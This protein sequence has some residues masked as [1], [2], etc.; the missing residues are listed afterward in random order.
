MA[1]RNT[2]SHSPWVR[3]LSLACTAA[4]AACA[5]PGT[6][7]GAPERLTPPAVLKWVPDSAATNVDTRYAIVQFDA[8]VSER[9]SAASARELKDLVLISP[10]HGDIDVDWRRSSLRI[11]PKNGWKKNTTYTITIAPG[12]SDLQNNVRD[13]AIITVF[14]TGGSL[15]NGSIRGT[16]FNWETGE[17]AAGAIVE[18]VPTSDTTSIYITKTDSIGNFKLRTPTGNQFVVRSSINTLGDKVFDRRMA[19]DTTVI[20]LSDTASVELRAFQRDSIGPSLGTIRYEDSTRLSV[21]FTGY[22]D[23]ETKIDVSQF[24]LFDP[25]SNA[26]VIDSIGSIP[27]S[28]DMDSTVAT[29]ILVSKDTSGKTDTLI[30]T[31]TSSIS[32]TLIR[33]D[34]LGKA[35][36][37][38]RSDT[39]AKRDTISRDTV[40]ADSIAAKQTPVKR[41]I[42]ALKR[43]IILYLSRPLAD[44]KEY[45]LAATGIKN[46]NGAVG[47]SKR[48]FKTPA[49][50]RDK[51][52]TQEKK[53]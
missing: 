39:L 53:D 15:D 35:D 16:V 14:S 20:T 7:P 40:T 43:E 21:S 47:D 38:I 30:R 37:L 2:L 29:D 10:R 1:M 28:S 17:P 52:E 22:L 46:P 26:V 33:T 45:T 34:T 32:D 49:K 4:M 5:S 25:D 8:V 9:P 31:D 3:F 18:G 48:T 23:P 13:T 19:F 51:S 50:K 41:S 27:D 6:P 24:K 36:T 11:R 12:I 44:D 42:P